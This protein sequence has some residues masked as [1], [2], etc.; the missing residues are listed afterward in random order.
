MPLSYALAMHATN[1][2]RSCVIVI[3][4]YAFAYLFDGHMQGFQSYR[5]SFLGRKGLS[6]HVGYV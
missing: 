1:E 3:V 2:V 5:G 4:S 6:K